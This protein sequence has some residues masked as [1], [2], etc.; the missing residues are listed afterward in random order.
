MGL[1]YLFCK[2]FLLVYGLLFHD[3]NSVFCRADVSNLCKLPSPAPTPCQAMPLDTASKSHCYSKGHQGFP[4][5]YLL[6]AVAFYLRPMTYLEFI[7]KVSFS[8]CRC[9]VV[10]AQNLDFYVQ[11][12]D[13]RGAPICFSFYFPS[14]R[15]KGD[16][17]TLSSLT[18]TS[19]GYIYPS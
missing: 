2:Y 16:T 8:A 9:L 10:P 4:L 12:P 11:T 19:L 13:S 7:F 14:N 3:L 18:H 1:S 6:A 5:H 17:R 15:D